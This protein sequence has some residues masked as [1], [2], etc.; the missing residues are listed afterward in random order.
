MS[1]TDR[2]DRRVWIIA[3]A[4]SCGPLMS[5]LDSTMVN[6]G[7][8]T[9]GHVFHTSLAT[10]QWITSG[11]LL[12]LALALPLSGWLID[13]VGAR[14]IFLGCF[15]GFLVFSV[16]SG[17]AQSV[18][19]LI[20]CRVMQGIASGLLAP[21]MQMMMARHA[22]RHMA[23]V[24][25]VAAMPVMI[26]QMLGPSLGGLILAWASWR[27]IF[28]VN[29]PVGL[30]AI[31]F[32][33]KALPRDEVTTARRLDLLGFA[34]ISPGLAL[35]LQGM[36]SLAHGRTEAVYSLVAS[37]TLLSG[38]AVYGLRY[39]NIALIDL[40]LFKGATFRAAA[41]TQF[42]SN[43]INFGGQLLIPLYFL[44]A[45]ALSPG[46]TGLL[47]A[48][49]GLGVFCALPIMGRLSERFGARA[50]SGTGAALSLAGTLPF[51]LA[52]P[53]TPVAVLCAALLVRGFGG[54][55]ITIPSAAAAYASVPRESLGHAT[56]AIN[57]CQR[58]GG[59]TGS[60]GLA[61][62]LQFALARTAV[63]AQAFA[64]T[65][66]LLA[67]V[68]GAALLAA[69]RLPGKRNIA[70]AAGPVHRESVDR[71]SPAGTSD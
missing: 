62:C 53:D 17:T 24:I 11:Y 19:M 2:V 48:P 54:G 30:L 33:W 31:A 10:I 27:W 66:W 3:A 59:P 43:A 29:V 12:A 56:T 15:G 61:I 64:I 13:R 35:L 28:F 49:M 63:P 58:F 55:S 60:A 41:G 39:P 21:M 25:G 52:G 51:A 7:L 40:R 9:M 8:D 16:M 23:R 47:L 69:S 6:V 32:A 1:H 45:R 65:F 4:C 34:M 46:L 70:V 14:R 57:I 22:G 50:I 44:Q 18:Q 38:F 42:L 36:V 5:G 71:E 37:V 67:G 68:A 20:A 26:G